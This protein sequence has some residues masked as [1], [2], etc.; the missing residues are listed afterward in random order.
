MSGGAPGV[1]ELSAQIE[2]LQHQLAKSRSTLKAVKHGKKKKKHTV[3]KNRSRFDRG[4]GKKFPRF[5]PPCKTRFN[6]RAKTHAYD[7]H[8]TLLPVSS[9][10]GGFFFFSPPPPFFFGLL[11]LRVGGNA[12][13]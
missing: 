9:L 10:F 6:L 7:R 12:T 2:D 1:R 5:P 8:A 13:A 3:R 11:T 4:G